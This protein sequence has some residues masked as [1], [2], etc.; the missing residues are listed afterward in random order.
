MPTLPNGACLRATTGWTMR[1]TTGLPRRVLAD[2]RGGANRGDARWG[3]VELT[4]QERLGRRV[5]VAAIGSS[6]QACFG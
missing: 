3:R 6:G 1:R 5:G 2:P 4:G